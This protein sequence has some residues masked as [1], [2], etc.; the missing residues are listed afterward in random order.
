MARA[1]LSTFLRCLRRAVAPSA[2]DGLTDGVLLERFVTDGDAA[3]FELLVWRH[4][5]MV[6]GVCRRLLGHEQDAEDAFQAAFLVLA[7][8]AGSIRKGESVG[9]FLYGVAYRIAMKERTRLFQRRKREQRSGPSMPLAGPAY[10]AA[11]RELQVVLDEGLNRLP[12]KY[13]APFVLCCLEGRS[14]AEAARELGWKEGTVAS[15]LAQA[16]QR[17]QRLLDRKGV[18]LSAAMIAVG[19]AG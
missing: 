16:R 19:I 6:L 8:K 17:L 12:E 7:R 15:R 2:D 3:A 4:G 10:E 1:P 5:P 13:R 9:S 18:T 14:K 11:W